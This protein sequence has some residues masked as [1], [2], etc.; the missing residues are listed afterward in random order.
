[1]AMIYYGWGDVVRKKVLMGYGYC[2]NCQGI[3]PM[4]LAKHAFRVHICYIP[5]F[6]KTKGYV[7]MCGDCEMG[8]QISKEEF[9]QLRL[10]YEPMPKKLVK[11]CYKDICRICSAIADN[12]QANI[13]Y[14]MKQ[15][16]SQYPIATNDTLKSRYTAL[17]TDMLTIQMQSRQAIAQSQQQAFAEN[18]QAAY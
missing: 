13:D 16:C 14:V 11:K 9:K 18:N 5:V 17:V 15:I 2:P 3:T 10:E 4:Y 1:M 6:W 8:H 12:S 7:E